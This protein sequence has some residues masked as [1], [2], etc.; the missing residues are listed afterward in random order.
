MRLAILSCALLPSLAFAGLLKR[1]TQTLLGDFK[2]ITS[3]SAKVQQEVEAFTGNLN[4]AITIYSDSNTLDAYI[5]QAITDAQALGDL[6][7]DDSASVANAVT[8]LQNTAFG[9]LNALTAK[10]PQFEQNGVG[11]VNV[12][13]QTLS[14]LKNDTAFLGFVITPKLVPVL[15][16][17]SPLLTSNI[18]FHFA[19]AVDA[20]APNNSTS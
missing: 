18:D 3:Q 6:N 8:Q 19:R 14:T 10:K 1:D 4:D 13:E 7:D 17:V 9:T 20:F 15:A 5:K 12:V 11:V 16:K 2:N